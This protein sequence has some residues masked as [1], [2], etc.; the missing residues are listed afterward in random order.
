MPLCNVGDD[1]IR[2]ILNS[3]NKNWETSEP[4]TI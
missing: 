3:C 4:T 1:M 2:F